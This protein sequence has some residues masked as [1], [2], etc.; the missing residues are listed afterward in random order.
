MRPRLRNTWRKPLA[1]VFV[2]ISRNSAFHPIP[3]VARGILR[4]F[5][6][7]IRLTAI[8][9]IVALQIVF[10]IVE[11]LTSSA[12]AA[13]SLITGAVCRL[14]VVVSRA[15]VSVRTGTV[16]A[17]PVS[18]FYRGV[19]RLGAHLYRPNRH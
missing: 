4:F 10:D 2:N 17:L 15:R 7:H 13:V 3:S 5:P 18:I 19:D 14:I 8:C 9:F 1:A 16:V 6:S 11:A 12:I